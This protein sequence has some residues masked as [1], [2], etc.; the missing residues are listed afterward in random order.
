MAQLQ[1]LQVYV[2]SEF[3]IGGEQEL[4]SAVQPKTIY[5][6]GADPSSPHNCYLDH[7]GQ[8]ATSSQSDLRYTKNR[9]TQQSFT[10]KQ[11]RTS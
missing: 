7:G 9:K 6:F 1:R 3:R 2:M 8:F 10:P 5:L 4:K 11:S